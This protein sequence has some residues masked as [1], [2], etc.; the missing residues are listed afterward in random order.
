MK[1]YM[2]C[3]YTHLNHN[4]LISQK[5]KKVVTK[6]VIIKGVYCIYTK[7]SKQKW[8]EAEGERFPGPEKHR[9]RF[10]GPEKDRVRFHRPVFQQR[11]DERVE[12]EKTA[13]VRRGALFLSFG[14]G[15]G[16]S[17]NSSSHGGSQ[18]KRWRTCGLLSSNLFSFLFLMRACLCGMCT[19]FTET[20]LLLYTMS[21]RLVIVSSGIQ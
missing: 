4:L 20:V 18:E 10:P 12:R 5:Q 14:Y 6:S 21:E 7:H 16:Y 1:V 8:R 13:I 17:S 9:A 19:D 3:D 2:E 15:V 11:Q